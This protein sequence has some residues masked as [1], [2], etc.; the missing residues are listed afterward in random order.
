MAQEPWAEAPEGS[1]ELLQVAEGA[2]ATLVATRAIGPG[3]AHQAFRADSEST[4]VACVPRPGRCEL[5]FAALAGNHEVSR[6][7]NTFGTPPSYRGGW[8][9]TLKRGPILQTAC[10]HAMGKCEP[11]ADVTS[12]RRFASEFVRFTTNRQRRPV[13]VPAARGKG[14][15]GHAEP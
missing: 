14:A 12:R 2:L 10:V 1:D 9:M 3:V 5:S 13:A 6:D 11:A 4:P 7:R 8:V 15:I